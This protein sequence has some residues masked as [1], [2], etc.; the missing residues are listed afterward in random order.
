MTALRVAF[1][2]PIR[3]DALGVE[4]DTSEFGTLPEFKRHRRP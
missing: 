3:I 2:Q 4:L 1:G